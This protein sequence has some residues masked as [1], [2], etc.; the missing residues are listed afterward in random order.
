MSQKH[1]FD[2]Q[3]I[4]GELKVSQGSLGEETQFRSAGLLVA[5]ARVS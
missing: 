5:L 2:S 4:Q 3:V 1:V